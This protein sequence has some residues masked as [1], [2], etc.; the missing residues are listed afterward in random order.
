MIVKAR[1]LHLSFP[2]DKRDGHR[3]FDEQKAM[4]LPLCRLLTFRQHGPCGHLHS[5]SVEQG[6]PDRIFRPASMQ[7]QFGSGY[8]LRTVVLD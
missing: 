1:P 5:S 7:I 6:S 3:R 2:S 8:L 4:S